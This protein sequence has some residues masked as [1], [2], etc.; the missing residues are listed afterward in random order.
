MSQVRIKKIIESNNLHNMIVN[1]AKFQLDKVVA[2]YR[3]ATQYPSLISATIINCSKA[4]VSVHSIWVQRVLE[5]QA[6]TR[7]RQTVFS[8]YKT[9]NLT[10]PPTDITNEYNKKDSNMKH[11]K[12]T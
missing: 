1:F 11:D 2:A 8:D 7:F 4:S 12:S 5:R 6:K 10:S 3:I 9:Y